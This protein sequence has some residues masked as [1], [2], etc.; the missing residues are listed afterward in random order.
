[1]T[2][3]CTEG[4]ID[5]IVVTEGSIEMSKT[6][7]TT[8]SGENIE[9]VVAIEIDGEMPQL[10]QNGNVYHDVQEIEPYIS[11]KGFQAKSRDDALTKNDLICQV[12]MDEHE[13]IGELSKE[14][15]LTSCLK[16]CMEEIGEEIKK[17]EKAEAE[18][19]DLSLFVHYMEVNPK[20]TYLTFKAASRNVYD[21]MRNVLKSLEEVTKVPKAKLEDNSYSVTMHYKKRRRLTRQLLSRAAQ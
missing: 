20:E 19:N 1:M 21:E 3:I 5:H 10:N 15:L 14:A 7:Q 13:E 16:S 9:I 12:G 11:A 8:V 4:L 18:D 2:K 17:V 6:T